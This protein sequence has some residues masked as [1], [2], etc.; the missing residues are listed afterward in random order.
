L[1]PAVAEQQAQAAAEAARSSKEQLQAA[2][3][4]HASV[5]RQLSAAQDQVLQLAAEVAGLNQQ[6]AVRPGEGEAGVSPGRQQKLEAQLAASRAAAERVG[7]R[8]G[9]DACQ[10]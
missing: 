5:C 9:A 8:V 7:M 2:R 10:G 4:D 1:C 3:G 6:L